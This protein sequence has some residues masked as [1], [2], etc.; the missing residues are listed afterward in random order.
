MVLRSST[1][2]RLSNG[3]AIFEDPRA[4]EEATGPA[5]WSLNSVK[6]FVTFATFC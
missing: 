3:A 2:S 4:A 5:A 1:S 6:P